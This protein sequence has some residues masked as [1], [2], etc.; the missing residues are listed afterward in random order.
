MYARTALVL[1]SSEKCLN[2]VFHALTTKYCKYKKSAVFP[3][4]MP[5][6]GGTG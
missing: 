2:L 4:V 1:V 3:S 5:H 6:L